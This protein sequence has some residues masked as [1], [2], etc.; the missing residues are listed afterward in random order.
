MIKIGV[1]PP[2]PGAV[3]TLRTTI[4]GPAQA[5]EGGYLHRVPLLFPQTS[6]TPETDP[7]IEGPWLFAGTDQVMLADGLSPEQ[8]RGMLT[9]QRNEVEKRLS[10]E[11]ER[12]SA[13][14]PG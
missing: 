2:Q 3:V 5:C 13:S 9:M 6:S 12:L 7:G 8:L 4:D 11:Q 1:L 14:K 10:D